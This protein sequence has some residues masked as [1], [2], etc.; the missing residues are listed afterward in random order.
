MLS[1]S[2]FF[3]NIKASIRHSMFLSWLLYLSVCFTVI[4][5]HWFYQWY[6]PQGEFKKNIV[7]ELKCINPNETIKEYE[8]VG[9]V[10]LFDEYNG[11]L[12]S[13][14]QEYKFILELDVPES[15]SN[16]NIGIFGVT[17]ELKDVNDK[18]TDI[19]KTT[20]RLIFFFP[21]LLH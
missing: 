15:E 20:V 17:G 7:F 11:I 21:I 10:N 14:G 1:F 2:K 16:F 9:L 5:Y 12:L 3:Q 19:F 8:L 6:I 18:T 13:I 4:I